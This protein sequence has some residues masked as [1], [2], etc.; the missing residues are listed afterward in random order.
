LRQ[1]SQPQRERLDRRFAESQSDQCKVVVVIRKRDGNSVPA[2]FGTE[3]QAAAFIKARIAKGTV[4]NADEA[5]AWNT[6]HR[7]AA[8][9]APRSASIIISLAPICLD[10]RKS[11]RGE[12]IT[13]ASRNGDQVNRITALAL[14]RGKS[15]DFTG[16]WQR[17]VN[18]SAGD[19][20]AYLL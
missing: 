13:A 19:E 3:D 15:V 7:T 18:A 11:H 17:Y 9:V 2:V 12:K 5:A 8:C 20:F 10:M 6:L 16:Y 14:K 4:V 1:A